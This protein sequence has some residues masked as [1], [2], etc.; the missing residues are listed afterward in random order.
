VLLSDE[1]VLSKGAIDAIEVLL[2]AFVRFGLPERILSDNAKAFTSFVYRLLMGVLRVGVRYTEPGHP[3]ENPYAESLIGTLRAYSNTTRSI[4]PALEPFTAFPS[5]R[6]RTS[7]GQAL[8]RDDLDELQIAFESKAIG[9]VCVIKNPSEDS[10]Q[11]LTA[12]IAQIDAELKRLTELKQSRQNNVNRLKAYLLANP[13]KAS[14][15]AMKNAAIRKIESGV[16]R[17]RIL[18]PTYLR[19]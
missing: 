2:N 4:K 5:L 13:E 16:H 18:L 7:Y 9:C 11:V 3:W 6:S 14:G 10:G 1:T 17:V 12:E 15:Q 8:R 19:G